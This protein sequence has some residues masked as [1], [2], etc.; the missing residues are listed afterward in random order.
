MLTC[1]VPPVTEMPAPRADPPLPFAPASLPL[2]MVSPSNTTVPDVMSS[3]RL[4]AL[5]LTVTS[6]VPSL[7]RSPSIVRFLAM[8]N[9]PVV[10]VM[11]M[12]AL[13]VIVSPAPASMMVWR[14]VPTPLSA[15]LV[16][17]RRIKSWAYWVSAAPFKKLPVCRAPLEISSS[18][19]PPAPVRSSLAATSAPVSA[20]KLLTNCAPSLPC[21]VLQA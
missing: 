17:V 14:S 7:S 11:L 2:V 18:Q 4:A 20:A 1:V 3:T 15:L 8:L 6:A 10:S 21:A 12:P 5:P 16:T 13:N 19:S 9:W